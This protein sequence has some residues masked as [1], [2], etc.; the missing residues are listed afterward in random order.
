[1]Y[2]SSINWF[3]GFAIIFVVFSHLTIYPSTFESGY[4]NF[5]SNGTFYFVFI[6]GFLF[7]HL[8]AKFE[9][10][11]Y[12]SRKTKY[13]VLPY[14][15]IS[16][17]V[18]AWANYV[19]FSGG[20]WFHHDLIPSY[21]GHNLTPDYFSNVVYLNIYLLSTGGALLGPWWFI[22][23]I[24]VFFIASYWIL[25]LSKSRYLYALFIL[26]FLFTLLSK[27]P[28]AVSPIVSFFYWFSVYML[29][30]LSAKNY[31]NLMKNSWQILIGSFVLLVGLT[32][33]EL[34]TDAVNMLHVRSLLVTFL[35]LSMFHL[36]E[37][38]DI[39]LVPLDILAK[40]SFGI[41]FLHKYFIQI[42]DR[43]IVPKLGIDKGLIL[44]FGTGCAA[45]LLSIITVKVGSIFLARLKLNP[46][47]FFGV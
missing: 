20:T 3:R 2:L 38:K 18:L 45:I 25:E 31:T 17:P 26:S 12:L 28:D 21:D 19:I 33:T 1:M 37:N 42:Q 10:F 41:F 9:Y 16:L 34:D 23:M 8:R 7:Y 13:V 24:C 15:F 29:G 46:R 36:L 4:T 11:S 14:I 39:K 47:Y 32:V 5:F 6:S 22:P 30:L 40:Y 44:F 43:I 35:V 27:R